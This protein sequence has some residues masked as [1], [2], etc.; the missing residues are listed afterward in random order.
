GGGGDGKLVHAVALGGGVRGKG[1]SPIDGSVRATGGGPLGRRSAW[2]S[3]W[4]GWAGWGT[5]AGSSSIAGPDTH[6]TEAPSGTTAARPS[7]TGA[8]PRRRGVG[9]RTVVAGALCS[10]EAGGSPPIRTSASASS[11]PSTGTIGIHE[12]NAGWSGGASPAAMPSPGST[13]APSPG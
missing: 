1:A 6:S 12:S 10:G 8:G 5:G 11:S 2:A 7:Y 4:A 13:T 3:G 9:L